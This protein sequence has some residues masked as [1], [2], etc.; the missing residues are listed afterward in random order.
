MD[1]HASSGRHPSSCESSIERLKHSEVFSSSTN[2]STKPSTPRI[3]RGTKDESTGAGPAKAV[4]PELSRP[5]HCHDW[6][7]GP[8]SPRTTAALFWRLAYPPTGTTGALKSHYRISTAALSAYW[9]LQMF[10]WVWLGGRQA[11]L[12]RWYKSAQ[13]L[14]SGTL[15]ECAATRDAQTRIRGTYLVV[16]FS[17]VFSKSPIL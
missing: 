15:Q 5:V 7:A 1:R 17:P 2:P 13:R 3:W 16:V 8:Q 4:S 12:T 6:Q 9:T 10:W 11:G 14:G